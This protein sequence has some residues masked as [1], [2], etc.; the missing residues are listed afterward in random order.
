MTDL[1]AGSLEEPR[2]DERAAVGGRPAFLR[3]FVLVVIAAWLGGFLATIALSAPGYLGVADADTLSETALPFALD[4]RWAVVADIGVVVTVLWAVTVSVRYWLR[5]FAGGAPAWTWIGLTLFT[6]GATASLTFVTAGVATALAAAAMR[7][8]VY[9][10][11]GT[12]RPEPLAFAPTRAGAVAIGVAIPVVA[13]GAATAYAVYHP[14]VDNSD[15]PV[16]RLAA[17]TTPV[18]ILGPPISNDGGVAIRLLA[19]EPG[20]ERGYA[21]HLTNVELLTTVGDMSH[22]VPFVPLT[23][24]PNDATYSNIAL[25]IS[26][27]GC[28]PG[29]SGRIESVRVRYDLGGERTA[30]VR[31]GQPIELT[32]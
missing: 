21:L 30:L 31:L 1:A 25:E 15:G 3:V 16:R 6:A 8:T 11:D 19:I 14:L 12:P 27:S 4:T 18:H 5:T 28:R 22:R 26:R 20:V 23:L 32:C 10:A 7:W 9:G 24:Q 13:I 2:E 29:S 17:G